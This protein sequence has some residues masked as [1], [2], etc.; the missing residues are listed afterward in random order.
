MELSQILLG[1]KKPLEVNIYI[2]NIAIDK[3]DRHHLNKSIKVV[4]QEPFLF[5]D[6]IFN[7][8]K[9]GHSISN[10]RIQ[11][12]CKLCFIDDYVG[13]LKLKYDKVFTER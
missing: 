5:Q 4:I 2:N 13:L 12:I 11:N 1:I 3:I 8:I 9:L 7:N 6:T 10:E